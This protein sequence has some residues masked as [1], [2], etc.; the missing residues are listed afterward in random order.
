MGSL[1][2]I[3]AFRESLRPNN[4]TQ[5][6]THARSKGP[7]DWL[8]FARLG[9]PTQDGPHSQ[10]PQAAGPASPA[11]SWVVAAARA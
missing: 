9:L 5:I 8:A 11:S 2:E 1:V 3:N 10:W 7:S 6:H 4:R